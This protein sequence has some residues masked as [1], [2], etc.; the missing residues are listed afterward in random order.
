MEAMSKTAQVLKYFAQQYQAENGKGIPRKR[1]I[2]MAYLTDLLAREYLGDPI[3]DFR[4]YLYDFG[5]YD[6]EIESVIAE[7]EAAGLAETKLEWGQ[8][9]NIKRLVDRGVPVAFDFTLVES[10]ILRYVTT[11]YLT[12]PMHELMDEIVYPSLPMKEAK[13]KE[14]LP[15]GLMD[16]RGRKAVGFDLEAVL[17][18]EQDINRG[19]FTTALE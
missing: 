8:E 18:A 15:M 2:K 7:L 11:N 4:Y 13:Y 19:N 12:M 1:L 16:N 5:P 9:T 14:R 6:E 3:T 17:R 10:E